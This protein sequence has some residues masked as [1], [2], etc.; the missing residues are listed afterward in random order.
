[1]VDYNK[2]CYIGQELTAR[3]HYRALIK[4]RLL[5]VAVV[6]VAPQPGTPL[7]SSTNGDAGEMRSGAGDWGLALVRLDALRGPDS[8]LTTE[9]GARLRPQIPAWMKLP[10][11]E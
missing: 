10:A 8:V 9:K 1:G 5:P 4:K 7:K 6:G 11:S 2:G 3:T